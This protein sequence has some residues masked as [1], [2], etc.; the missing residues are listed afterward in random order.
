LARG[1][2]IEHWELAD[3]LVID[4]TS[5]LYFDDLKLTSK[6]ERQLAGFDV[7][8]ID[9]LSTIHNADENSV[10]RM[11]PIMN[12]WR[13]MSLKT[14][15]AIPLVHHFRKRGVDASNGSGGGTGN[16]LQRARGSSL[17]AATTRHAVGIER[18]PGEDELTVHIESNHEVD[19]QPFVIRRRFGAD[20][21]GRKFITHERAGNLVDARE[22][23]TVE[24][25]DPIVLEIIRKAG[26]G[27]IGGRD[28]RSAAIER[29]TK[30]RGKGIRPIK[31]D[32]SAERLELAGK[33]RKIDGRWRVS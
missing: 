18:G 32:Q 12:R 4:A 10:E 29:V 6:L 23:R 16:V 33:I 24:L 22:A 21:H 17:I 19:T 5:P 25:V 9:S 31:V 14:S 30:L 11:A 3:H 26:A 1:A 7:C 28:L 27:G 20:E 15:T 2:G 8:A 13:D